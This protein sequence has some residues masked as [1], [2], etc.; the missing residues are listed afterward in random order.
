MRLIEPTDVKTVAIL[1]AG[2]IGASWAVHFLSQGMRVNIWDP[3]QDF[4]AR[5]EQFIAVTWNSLSVLRDL[6]TLPK[7]D[8][9]FFSNPLDAV[10]DADFIQESG[11]ENKEKKLELF[12][13]LD[14][15][16]RDNVVLA[17]SSSGL[18]IS[19]LQANRIGGERYVI[20]HPFNPPHIIPLVEVVGGLQTHQFA[21][22]WALA[23]YDH[24]GKKAIKINR[25]VPGH[26]AN[27]LQAAMWREA[28]HLLEQGVASVEDID[29]AV[30]YGP[31]LRWALMGPNLILHLAGGM[32]GIKHAIDHLGPSLEKWWSDL[33]GLERISSEAKKKLIAGI[34]VEVAG[35]SIEDLVEERDALLELLVKTLNSEKSKG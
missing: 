22:D 18:L 35:R 12:R 34:E 21:I 29:K 33:S 14:S 27:R 16:F 9:I 23:F 1:G 8:I 32:G 25:E 31:G 3:S 15:N 2:T 30:S 19:E 7:S 4:Q 13:A 10:S 17:S 26:L 28:I 24:C 11:P 20:G 6:G 5:I